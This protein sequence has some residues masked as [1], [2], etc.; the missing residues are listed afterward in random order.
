MNKV[1][2]YLIIR[3]IDFDFLNLKIPLNWI[4]SVRKINSEFGKIETLGLIQIY[5]KMLIFFIISV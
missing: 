5:R 3:K 2:V 1:K 4:C